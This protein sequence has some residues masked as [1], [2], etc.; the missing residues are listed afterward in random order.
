MKIAVIGAGVAGI[1]VLREL[2]KQM[3]VHPDLDISLFDKGNTFGT[4]LP[5]QPDHEELLLNQ[6]PET[7]SIVP[8][9][10]EHFV[11]W[12]K[13]NSEWVESSGKHLPRKVYGEYLQY[14]L[15]HLV[16]ESKAQ[17]HEEKVNEIHLKEDGRLLVSYG[18]EKELFDAVHLCVGHL[19]YSDPYQ[20]QGENKYIRH[21]YPVKEKLKEVSDHSRVGIIGTGLT[22]IDLM[23]YLK[24]EKKDVSICFTSLDGAFGAVRGEEAPVDLTYFSKKRILLE[25]NKNNGFIPLETMVEWFKKEAALQG[26]DASNIWNN[27]G[28]GTI[29][30]LRRDLNNLDAIGRF[31][32][33]IHQLDDCLPEI[34]ESLTE[35]DKDCFLSTYGWKWNKFRSPIPK[36]TA[37]KIIDFYEKG[38]V[39]L[40]GVTK[41]VQKE[42]DGF[43]IEFE[44]KKSIQVD[45]VLNASGQKKD[46]AFYDD[47]MPLVTQLLNEQ[48]LQKERMGGVQVT[49]PELSAISHRYGILPQLKVH[50]QLVSGIQFGNNTMGMISSS[51]ICAV[52]EMFRWKE[53]KTSER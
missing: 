35:K 17:I 1:S 50:G 38:I 15:S 10:S 41:D 30:G 29:Q 14:F 40:F 44:N 11:K 45:Y 16:K 39:Q 51:A 46:L 19:P 31:Q 28:E 27:Y 48:V 12:L 5:Y 52:E 9:D 23:L 43:R 53:D 20:L 49:W 8:D 33:V 42:A 6:T 22:A 4:G 47:E 26:V 24:K 7:M 13:K 25:R 34:W 2:V 21:P 36:K 18:D 32:S 3:K 37:V